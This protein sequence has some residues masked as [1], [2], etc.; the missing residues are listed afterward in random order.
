MRPGQHHPRGRTVET[1]TLAELRHLT[2]TSIHAELTAPP[3]GLAGCPASTTSTSRAT[4]S[5]ARSTRPELDAVLRRLAAG[6][7][8]SLVGQPPTLEEL[9]LRHYEDELPGHEP[10]WRG[11]RRA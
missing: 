4:G 8:E 1:G 5:A 9:F 6:G 2:R 7:V 10:A 11:A 3:N